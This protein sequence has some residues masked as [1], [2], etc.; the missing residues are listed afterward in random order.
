MSFKAIKIENNLTRTLL[1]NT[2]SKIETLPTS[3][4]IG[5]GGLTSTDNEKVAI[6]SRAIC[7]ED[8]SEWVLTP[9]NT[10][11]KVPKSS[12]SSSGESSSSDE[13]LITESEIDSIIDSL[14]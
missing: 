5:A 12:N 8:W 11:N 13:D 4:T 7:I 3:T 6:G 14:S 1:V 2:L 9:N 10:W